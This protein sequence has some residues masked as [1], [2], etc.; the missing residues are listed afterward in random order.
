MIK[1]ITQEPFY[2]LQLL[3]CGTL[4]MRDIQHQANE[5]R[6]VYEKNNHKAYLDYRIQDSVMTIAHTWVPRA[7]GG[8]G[9]AADLTKKALQIAEKN[10]WKVNPACSY[11]ARYIE[12]HPQYQTLLT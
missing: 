10:H 1:T 12:K 9:I 6:F 8:Q 2:F 5:H 3:F 11:A 4:P 7:L